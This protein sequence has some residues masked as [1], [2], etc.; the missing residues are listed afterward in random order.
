M[1]FDLLRTWNNIEKNKFDSQFISNYKIKA[2]KVRSDIDQQIETEDIRLK[3]PNITQDQ[4]YQFKS[5]KRRYE[6]YKVLIDEIQKN[7]DSL[8]SDSKI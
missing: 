4:E 1:I 6:L 3:Q 7:G 8:V 5:R 2:S